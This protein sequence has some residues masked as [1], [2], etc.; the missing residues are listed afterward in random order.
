VGLGVLE[1][2]YIGLFDIV[3]A[4]D[5]RNTGLGYLVCDNI[6]RWGR[7]QG[8]TMAY[9][10]VLTNNSPAISLYKKM[11]FKE[12]YKYWYRMKPNKK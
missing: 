11:G 2:A 3:V 1:G 12:L 4:R 7:Q 9:L 6:L 10:Q 5:Y 8:A